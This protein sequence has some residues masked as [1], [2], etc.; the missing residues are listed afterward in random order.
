[1]FVLGSASNPNCSAMVI[2]DPVKPRAKR[3]SSHFHSFSDPGTSFRTGRFPG[4]LTH[5]TSE[6]INP[7]KLPSLSPT[8]R[9]VEMLKK[10]SAP[11]LW[12]ELVLN[13]IGQNG[14][15]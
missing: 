9:L 11:S 1:M 15:G 5:S 6:V 13:R 12:E 14:H 7:F 2:S 4:S 3:A 8:N 10:R